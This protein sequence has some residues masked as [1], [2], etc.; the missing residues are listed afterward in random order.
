MA[1][2]PATDN[3]NI[4]GWLFDSTDGLLTNYATDTST[5]II[6]TIAPVAVILFGIFVLLWAFA[7][8]RN[9]ID[10]PVTDGAMRLIKVAI[11]LGIALNITNYGNYVVDFVVD[12]PMALASSAAPTANYDN[13]STIG[14]VLDNALNKGF[15]VGQ[16]AW[17]QGGITAPG[18]VIIAIVIWI[19][20]AL[21]L[22]FAAML[23]MLSKVALVVLLAVG[24]IFI[25]LMLFQATQRFFEVW[26]GQVVNFMVTILLAV[27]VTSLL[28]TLVDAFV[29]RLNA[30]SAASTGKVLLETVVMGGIGVLVLRQVPGIASAI[31]GGI[32]IST[33]GAFGASM[34]G[35]KGVGDTLTGKATR[36]AARHQRTR[37]R[38]QSYNQTRSRVASAAGSAFRRKNAIAK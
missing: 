10:E 16:K 27:M 25:M 35:T 20:F 30:D 1:P 5:R 13:S 9:T 14:R 15:K 17:N 6:H 8:F 12:T 28:M 11:I 22:L 33:M 2:A 4:F 21:I 29:T 3:M 26:L 18:P 34:K 23:I 36:D 24:P 19:S 7:H 37:A 38:A 31:A 32:A